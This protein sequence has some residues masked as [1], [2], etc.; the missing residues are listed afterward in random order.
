M[1][2]KRGVDGFHLTQN[3]VKWREL[4]NTVMNTEVPS[5]EK[6]LMTG[7]TISFT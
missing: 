3:K 5:K 6:N 1:D 7:A 2:M 4:V